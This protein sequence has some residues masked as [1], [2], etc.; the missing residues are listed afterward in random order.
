MFVLSMYRPHTGL[1]LLSGI[2]STS[3]SCL[4]EV[5]GSRLAGDASIKG[6]GCDGVEEEEDE[7][8]E[9]GARHV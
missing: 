5:R 3:G 1:P 8:E 2:T 6:G 9:E 7:E 4:C